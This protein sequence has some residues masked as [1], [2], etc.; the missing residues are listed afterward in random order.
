MSEKDEMRVLEKPEQPKTQ[1]SIV[2]I[3]SLWNTMMGVSLLSMPWALYQAGLVLGLAILLAMAFLC[4]YTAYLVIESPRGVD[5]I[6]MR[7][8]EF[9]D[10]CREYLGKP[11][12]II[13]LVFSIT[14]LIGAVLAYW[15]L[16]SNFLYFTGTLIYELINPVHNTDT[17]G[18][19]VICDIQCEMDTS[20][21]SPSSNITGPPILF[22]LR[23]D[24]IWQL[25]LTVP[26]LLAILT[27]PLL[28]FKSP[29]FFT[30][31]NVLGTIAVMYLLVFNGA[32]L[33][34][35]GITW[36]FRNSLSPHYVEKFSW[37]FPAL[38]GM[39]TM[40]YFIHNA[41]ITI[42]RN[43]RNPKNNTRD[44]SIG[45]GLVAFS[46]IFVAFTFY[47]A[48][49]LE[50]SCIHDNLLNNF[51]A[52]YP[53]SAVARVLILFQLITIMPLILFFIRSQISCAIFDGP[54]PGLLVVLLL[55]ATIVTTGVLVAIFYPNIGSIIRYFGAFSGMMYTY[56][57]PCVIHMRKRHLA[58]QL[59]IPVA[60]MHSIIA[61]FGV[62]NLIAQFLI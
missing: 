24:Q 16:M 10:I 60:V 53:Y 12:A 3:F 20:L 36:D 22:G 58:G 9:S 45:Y 51:R 17:Q 27:F 21:T 40:S 13:A 49:P 57:L 42:L 25:Q 33:I 29:T 38:T 50:R 8:V 14:V 4:F 23:F 37:N 62:V 30:K 2:T 18:E 56:A 52:A 34:K 43:Q 59:T 46:Y 7:T 35:C 32:R 31:F 41:I 44:L 54:Y 47:A 48:F 15:V 1:N 19:E 11:G 61:I 6:D 39:L 5:K 28:N 55:N 26:I